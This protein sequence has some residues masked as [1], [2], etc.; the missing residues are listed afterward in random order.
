MNARRRAVRGSFDWKFGFVLPLALWLMVGPAWV[1]SPFGKQCPTAA[2]QSISVTVYS[3]CGHAI[4]TEVR[5]P[6]PGEPGFVQCRCAEKHQDS[7]DSALTVAFGV[8]SER[9]IL[10]IPA[11]GPFENQP[12]RHW[13]SFE[14]VSRPPPCPPPTFV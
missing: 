1:S 11:L 8:L 6:Q 12:V 7:S 5:A 2:T 14:K 13:A 10:A 4:G 9:F 3:D